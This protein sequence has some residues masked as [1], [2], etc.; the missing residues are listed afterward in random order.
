MSP[1]PGDA[2][3]DLR[4]YTVAKAPEELK[5]VINA[6]DPAILPP[7]EKPSPAQ[8][9]VVNGTATTKLVTFVELSL[10]ARM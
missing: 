2:E 7:V 5:E 3:L 4:S 1:A 10:N 6:V 8:F 9:P